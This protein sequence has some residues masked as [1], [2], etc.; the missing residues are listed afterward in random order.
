[1]GRNN[2]ESIRERLARENV[3][4]Q[5]YQRGRIIS[6]YSMEA[7]KIKGEE[8][9]EHDYE[10]INLVKKVI[11]TFENFK[12]EEKVEREDE[13]NRSEERFASV[14]DPQSS[15]PTSSGIN[16]GSQHMDEDEAD[17]RRDLDKDED[18]KRGDSDEDDRREDTDDDEDDKRGV[19]P[20]TSNIPFYNPYSSHPAAIQLG[21]AGTAM[22]LT[23]ISNFTKTWVSRNT[24][25]L[26]N[27]GGHPT[28][29]VTNTDGEEDLEE[30]QT[31]QE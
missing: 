11:D 15:H 24:M 30:K 19:S 16:I 2:K 21:L 23:G 3:L 28:L 25:A 7:Y 20:P 4:I 18:D 29:E 31:S 10:S 6:Q 17:K 22:P 12:K 1:M 5:D 26:T 9:T 13:Y 8:T 27:P 14:S